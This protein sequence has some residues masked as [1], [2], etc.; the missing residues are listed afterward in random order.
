[1]HWID[2]LILI[3]DEDDLMVNYLSLVE[4]LLLIVDYYMNVDQMMMDELD[5]HQKM[6]QVFH[7][8]Y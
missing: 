8:L 4:Q 5:Q 7:H 2:V 6:I 3:V 1:M